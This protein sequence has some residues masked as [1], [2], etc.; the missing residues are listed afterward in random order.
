MDLTYQFQTSINTSLLKNFENDFF[1]HQSQKQI[2]KPIPSS[3][4]SLVNNEM[5]FDLLSKDLLSEAKT[6]IS[7]IN[8]AKKPEITHFTDK[9]L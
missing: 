5:D 6:K 2:N 8:Q 3:F 4:L 9:I 1:Q 7:S